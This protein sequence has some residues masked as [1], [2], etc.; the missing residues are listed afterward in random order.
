MSR[1]PK[2]HTYSGLHAPDTRPKSTKEL[3]RAVVDAIKP[4]APFR[5]HA[6][7]AEL[8]ND[9]KL[10]NLPEVLDRFRRSCISDLELYSKRQSIPV[11]DLMAHA[12]TLKGRELAQMTMV[13]DLLAHFI[14]TETKYAK[15][16]LKVEDFHVQNRTTRRRLKAQKP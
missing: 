14:D 1:T 11:P 6:T 15:G 3:K 13:L 8:R 2:P 12:L 7:I 10:L 9:D 5:D 16:I 4:H